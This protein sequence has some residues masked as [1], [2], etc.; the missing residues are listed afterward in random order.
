[1]TEYL[2]E[3]MNDNNHQIQNF[4]H[5]GLDII[6]VSH[7]HTHKNKLPININFYFTL[8][9]QDSD[10]SMAVRI[11]QERF[12]WHNY[13]WLTKVSGQ[14]AFIEEPDED[15]FVP[16]VHHTSDL[17][18]LQSTLESRQLGLMDMDYGIPSDLFGEVHG[19]TLLCVEVFLK[20]AD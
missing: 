15:Y 4:C 17:Y 11:Q 7:T 2:M 13:L 14:P 19:Y 3:L 18:D 12:R 6:A 20:K 5:K 9:L 8:Y 1:M 16:N 10:E